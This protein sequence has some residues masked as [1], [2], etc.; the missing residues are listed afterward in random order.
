M[1]YW[2]IINDDF[3]EFIILGYSRTVQTADER[4]MLVGRGR[5]ILILTYI[6][7]G[8]AHSTDIS[9]LILLF[10]FIQIL[11]GRRKVIIAWRRLIIIPRC[12]KSCV[13]TMLLIR[14]GSTARIWP[15][16]KSA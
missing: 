9:P 6:G 4:F 14:R 8:I 2:I 16:C 11:I 1:L 3:L 7:R 10:G 13:L 5:L 15:F 12:C